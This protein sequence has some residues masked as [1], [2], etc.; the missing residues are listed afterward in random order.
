MPVNKYS[1]EVRVKLD[2][3]TYLAL[4]ALAE[5]R[6]ESIS[7]VVRRILSRSLQSNTALDA[8][9]ILLSTVRKAVA[10]ELRQT[11]NRLASLSA[12]AAI[13]AAT[14]ENLSAYI[15]KQMN[16]PD[17]NQV[18]NAARSRG[19]AYVR[20]PLEKIMAAYPDNDSL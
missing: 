14:A 18:R 11:E 9:D 16:E 6:N 4:K 8:S 10:T 1:H 15:L 2:D 20:E 13:T 5:K 19:V 7:I 3:N 12:K 17:I